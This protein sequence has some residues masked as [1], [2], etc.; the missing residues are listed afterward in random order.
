MTGTRHT[1]LQIPEW[2][3]SAN[4]KSGI[5]SKE[6]TKLFGYSEGALLNAVD[7]GAF[8]APDFRLKS[9]FTTTRCKKRVYWRK[10]TLIAEVER[11]QDLKRD[12]ESRKAGET[13]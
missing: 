7:K 1:P 4:E 5:S 11:R 3:L 10:A 13:K 9:D 8:P 2:L 6:V 12:I